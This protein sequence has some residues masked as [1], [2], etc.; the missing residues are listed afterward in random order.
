M[1]L[2]ASSRP[3]RRRLLVR[4]PCKA[5]AVA[6]VATVPLAAVAPVVRAQ[7][8]LDRPDNISTDWVGTSGTLYFNF[9]HRFSQSAPPE[10]KVTN[11]PTFL[12]ATGIASR[13]LV[14]FNY[15]PTRHSRRATPTSTSSLRGTRRCSRRTE[16]HLISAVSSTTTLPSRVWTERCRSLAARGR[17]GSWQSRA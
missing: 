1:T 10:R 15:A 6:I 14:G 3:H 2:S 17:C 12:I 16:R 8:M 7:S 13:A 9:V 11:F 4:S 5:F